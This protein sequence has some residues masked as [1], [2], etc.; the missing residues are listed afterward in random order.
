MFTV[1]SQHAV[2]QR[3]TESIDAFSRG[4]ERREAM[5]PLP[6]TE[7]ESSAIHAIAQDEHESLIG[8]LINVQDDLVT[9][10]STGRANLERFREIEANCLAIADSSLSL[11]DKSE[12]LRNKI[13]T[14]RANIEATDQQL[15]SIHQIVKL[16]ESIADQTKLLALNATIEAARAGDAGKG[17][18][19]VATEVKEL[20]EQAMNAVDNIRST[21]SEL[22]QSSKKATVDLAE[23]ESEAN[24][25]GAEVGRYVG[26]LEHTNQLNTQATAITR[27]TSSHVFA[28]LAKIDHIL[29]KTRTY[30]STF[31]GAPT[32]EFVDHNH[33]RLGKWYRE[34]DGRKFKQAPSYRQL[35]RPHAAVHASTQDVFKILTNQAEAPDLTPVRRKLKE[36]E[37][38]SEDVFR[39]LDRVI[40]EG[41]QQDDAVRK[42]L[43]K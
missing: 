41:I 26:E 42:P 8:G 6:G 31:L 16:I 1:Q 24:E 34:G 15:K 4:L 10:E 23:I 35:E 17:F 43:A 5:A 7:A 12:T 20:S 38:A 33:C 11:S 37:R 40:Q 9:L 36:M 25:I 32:F 30:Q 2:I 28:T 14:T 21:V 29:W 18:A 19:V 3:K 22:L 27:Q 39:I 13:G